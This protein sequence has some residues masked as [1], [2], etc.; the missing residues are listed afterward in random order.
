[1]G[2]QFA[3]EWALALV[4]LADAVM[5]MVPVSPNW[6]IVRRPIGSYYGPL[7]LQPPVLLKRG[8]PLTWTTRLKQQKAIVFISHIGEEKELA[9]HFKELV[10]LAFLGM[11]DVF[12]S[13]DEHSIQMGQRWLDQ[14]TE[15]LKACAV[16]IVVCS[17][18]SIKR[19]W[20]NFEAGAGWIRNI[21]VVPL[22][23]SGMQP[24]ALPMPLNLLQAASA[25]E[26]SGLKLILPVLA[27]AIGCKTPN[28]DFTAFI[29]KVKDFEKRY[30][31]W[32]QACVA[33][34]LANKLVPGS[35]DQ[36]KAGNTLNVHLTETQ[37]NMLDQHATFLA[38]HEIMSMKANGSVSMGPGV[39][40][41]INW[42]PRS[43][44]KEVIDDTNLKLT[45]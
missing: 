6:G 16:E 4:S 20:I 39:F 10:E 42:V 3:T 23:H 28:L 11:I 14:I 34:S 9:I 1:M 2:S 19:P 18:A 33:L 12:V 26:V 29:V 35:L 21:P 44:F 36:L 30:T 22:C 7:Y 5:R 15:A 27:N 32:A 25:S 45:A 17:P 24:S 43:R 40:H 38:E 31:F 37:M 41:G 8:E 13:S